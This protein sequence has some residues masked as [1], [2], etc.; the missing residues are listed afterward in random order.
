MP[1]P[2]R[3]FRAYYPN[4]FFG[5]IVIVLVAAAAIGCRRGDGFAGCTTF[6]APAGAADANH[7]AVQTALGNAQPG[8]V[9]CFRGGTYALHDELTL[10]TPNVELRGSQATRAVFDFAGRI[11]GA[12]GLF[13]DGGGFLAD[14]LTIKNSAGQGIR[15][16]KSVGVT[17]RDVE[18]TWD[19]G[20]SA[21]NGGYGIY[22]TEST[23][24]VI[25]SC[26]VSYASDAGIYVGQSQHIVVRDNETRGNVI[27]IEI[28]NS[29]DAEVDHN[30]AHDNV[31]G[32][33]AFSLPN[34][35]R[36]GCQRVNIHDNKVTANNVPSFAAPGSIVSQVPS[37]TGIMIVAADQVV[38]W[39]ND[40]Q[41]NESIGIGVFSYLVTQQDDYKMDAAY[42]PYPHGEWIHDN[43]LAHNGENPHDKA[44]T[45][46]G[47]VGVQQAEQLLWDGWN[48]PN[49]QSPHN[50]ICFSGNKSS[51]RN[52]DFGNAFANS[53]TDIAPVTCT[54]AALAAEGPYPAP[55]LAPRRPTQPHDRLSD[56]GFFTG[57]LAAQAPA[58][59]V[60]AYDVAASLYADQ[61]KKLRF[62]ALPP[63][64]KI[65]FDPSGRWTFPDGTTFIKTF[66]FDGGGGA[67]TLAETRLEML[68]GG[69]WT[70]QTYLWDDAQTEAIRFVAGRT[71]HRP[72]GDY[73]VPASDQCLTCHSQTDQ[74]A[75]LGPRTRQLNRLV[76]SG[77]QMINQLDQWAQ[78]G[79]F[80]TAPPPAA[81]LERLVDPFGS[82]ALETRARS[83]LEAN[84]AHCHST[85]GTASSTNLRLDW[86][87]MDWMQLGVCKSPVSAGPGSGQLKFDVVP[88]DPDH[89]IVVL[90]MRSTE[91]QI[92]M[93]QLPTMTS[94]AAGTGLVSDWIRS[95]QLPPCPLQ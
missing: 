27:G 28:E 38:A 91:P 93:P 49:S 76:A 20:S 63:G 86:P 65:G 94:D 29:S 57:A 87:T 59:G 70:L 40:V 32:I 46:T 95:L 48:D 60:I 4:A 36:H 25:E 1:T 75:P 67:R 78:R 79:L 45:I 62:M 12:N 18:V 3:I 6:V 39:K 13:V 88:G 66:Y 77:A 55:P 64:G 8:D 80:T 54:G 17:L 43:S 2:P 34:L 90:R 69:V 11:R 73:R 10:S 47:V 30:D 7:D 26:K 50:G 85:G 42:N 21:Q 24:V 84:C 16:Q 9:I 82:D 83:Y 52:L 15:I 37:G 89:S 71:L 33:L 5:G 22:P 14:H 19:A 61:S 41:K 53:T 31:G 74:A 51:Y 72:D 56:Y 23:D 81:T 92:K 35:A 58:D 68:V 44:S